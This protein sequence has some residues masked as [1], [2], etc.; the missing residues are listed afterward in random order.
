M[1][2]GTA[3]PTIIVGTNVPTMIAGTKFLWQLF[4]QPLS[5]PLLQQSLW[6]QLFQQ[7]LWEQKNSLMLFLFNFVGPVVLTNVVG[8][9]IHINSSKTGQFNLKVFLG[10]H[11]QRIIIR[12]Y[13]ANFTE[14]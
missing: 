7:W 14:W 6:E 5:E 11:D 4:Q 3:V 9:T 8:T 13:M 1:I 2:V 10:G 12:G